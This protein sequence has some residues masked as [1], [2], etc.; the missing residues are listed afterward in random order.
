[1]SIRLRLT[2]LYSAILGLTLIAFSLALYFTVAQ[3][4]LSELK[5]TLK[6]ETQRLIV[7][8]QVIV[9]PKYGLPLYVQLL[10][11]EGNVVRRTPNLANDRLPISEENIRNVV[12][13]ASV[14]ETTTINGERL[15]V[16]NTKITDG[17]RGESIVLQVAR[18]LDGRDQSLDALRR[19]LIIGSGVALVVA[20]G[21]G[22]LLSGTALR[23]I[24]RITQTMQAIGNERD[25]GRRVTYAGPDDEIGRLA[26]TLNTMLAALQAAYRQEAQALQAQ[27]RFVAD[28][29]HELRT[30]LTTIRGNIGLLQRDPPISA[31]DRVA[32]LHDMVDESERMSRLVNDL[33]V[34]A[35]AD[36]GRQ[37]RSDP[38][39]IKPL[40]ED[41]CR[42]VSTLDPDQRV[43]CD[44]VD[45][46]VVRGD[47]DAIKQVLLILLDNAL[48]W[49]PPANE[50]TITAQANER[51][52]TIEVRDTGT[53]IAP[54]VLPHIFERFYRGDTSRTGGGAGLGLS[55]AKTLVEA[56]GGAIGV[57]SVVGEGSVFR[58]KLPRVVAATQPAE[59]EN[60]IHAL[61]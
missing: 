49:T 26:T 27:R 14:F 1:M 3:V 20:F 32:V 28:A 55:I 53:G 30:P 11:L 24:N 54:D 7:S 56:Q 36:A 57:H 33:L 50:I 6:N 35:R 52:A 61:S 8:G 16:Y 60:A 10:N 59:D 22:W 39:A 47:Q 4:T 58:V 12:N 2:L 29:S 19:I 44:D 23:P 9:D 15:L 17:W 38:L 25:F 45:D 31:D 43:S 48:K 21:V 46:A 5:A 42:K 51:F 18:S 13:G 41:V 37:L 34:L 40:I